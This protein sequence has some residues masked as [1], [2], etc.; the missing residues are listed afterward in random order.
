[1]HKFCVHGYPELCEQIKREGTGL[2]QDVIA[3]SAATA[4]AEAAPGNK[5]PSPVSQAPLVDPIQPFAWDV[6][7]EAAFED[8]SSDLFQS[9]VDEVAAFASSMMP[10]ASE[11]IDP[12]PLPHTSQQQRPYQQQ[13][14][15]SVM[16]PQHQGQPAFVKCGATSWSNTVLNSDDISF[17]KN[18]FQ[19]GDSNQEKEILDGFVLA[20]EQRRQQHQKPAVQQEL[21]P[22]PHIYHPALVQQFRAA[23]P[24]PVPQQ[25]IAQQKQK[26][27]QH[28]VQQDQ[29]PLLTSAA[30]SEYNFPRKLYRL[31]QDCESNAE[32]R[33]IV[34]WSQ[35]GTTFKVHCKK[36]FVTTILPNY[37]DQT[38]YASFRRQLNMYSFLRQSM[39]TYANPYFKRGH[40]ELLDHVVRKNGSGST[41]TKKN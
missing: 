11:M 35:D 31:L 2:A 24:M 30:I 27:Q 22:Q 32:Y 38:Q 19:P 36:R 3:V 28:A 14:Q 20:S 41:S 7:T 39:S 4:A 18:L 33:S 8:S 25:S 15:S 10:N 12:T 6:E 21:Q 37:F 5:Q 1:M 16:P 29:A 9:T 34:S 40:R 23:A 17:F 13:P 26:T